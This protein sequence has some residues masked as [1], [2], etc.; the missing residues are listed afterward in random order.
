MLKTKSKFVTR[1]V[2][3]AF[4]FATLNADGKASAVPSTA[5]NETVS[6]T[7]WS[8]PCGRVVSLQAVMVR[9]PS[10]REANEAPMRRGNIV[11]EDI[12]AQ[13]ADQPL[14]DYHCL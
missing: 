1:S 7:F 5:Y 10:T 4:G 3:T 2:R 6:I 13:R 9:S 8:S 12:A 11:A 14:T